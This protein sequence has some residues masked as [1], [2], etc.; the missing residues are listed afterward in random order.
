VAVP[1]IAIGKLLGA[2]TVFVESITRV[3]T[4]SLS[5]KLVRPCLDALYVHWP[6]LLKHYPQATLIPSQSI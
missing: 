2:K 1:F 5:A 6:Q 4:L 3:K